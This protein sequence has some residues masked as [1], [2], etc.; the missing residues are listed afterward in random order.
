[1]AATILACLVA[2]ALPSWAHVFHL[3]FF[4][5]ESFLLDLWWPEVSCPLQRGDGWEAGGTI[6]PWESVVG[7]LPSFF[8]VALEEPPWLL[9][10]LLLLG[11]LSETLVDFWEESLRHTF[12][13]LCKAEEDTKAC[14]R[15][16][17]HP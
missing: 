7:A 11:L 14:F 10:P 17:P 5:P 12:L 4:P 3:L 13:W 8:R 1:M 2:G 15:H 16:F 6:E 9:L